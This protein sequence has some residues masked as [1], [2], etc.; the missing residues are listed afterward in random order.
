M[1][2]WTLS[3]LPNNTFTQHCGVGPGGLG[4]SLSHPGRHALTLAAL[5][6]QQASG[7]LALAIS[8]CF[9]AVPKIL[10]NPSLHLKNLLFI[11]ATRTVDNVFLF[12]YFVCDFF[13]C[14][15]KIIDL[16]STEEDDNIHTLSHCRVH[17]EKVKSLSFPFVLFLLPSVLSCLWKNILNGL[18][19]LFSHKNLLWLNSLEGLAGHQQGARG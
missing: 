6:W 15:W 7:S 17:P 9:S 5:P 18:G 4:Q 1:W 14:V 11:L 8:Y 2:V 3:E 13:L 10:L 16:I 12:N 19:R